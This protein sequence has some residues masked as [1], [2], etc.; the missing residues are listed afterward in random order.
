MLFI[1]LISGFSTLSVAQSDLRCQHNWTQ[2]ESRCFRIF[3]TSSNWMGAEQN[4]VKMN[5]HLASLHSK[6]EYT[7]VQDLVVSATG[8]NAETW[9]G[10]TDVLQEKVWVWTDGSAFDYRNWSAG[11]PDDFLQLEHC[12]EMNFPVRWNDA[13]CSNK[14]PSACAKAAMPAKIISVI[15]ININSTKDSMES[16]MEELVKKLKQKLMD[17]GMPSNATLQLKRI[18]KKTT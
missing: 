15:K 11:Q 5:G 12:L 9:L 14:F 16:D 2:F 10:A 4:C 18:Y 13:P 17:S 6:E 7:F 1:L 8:S 3:T